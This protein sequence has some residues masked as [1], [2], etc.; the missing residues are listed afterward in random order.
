MSTRTRLAA[1][2]LAVLA[3]SALLA[4]CTV[5]P[6]HVWSEVR[7]A[8]L[9]A[10]PAIDDA[11]VVGATGP[12]GVDVRVR[13]YLADTDEVTVQ[14]VIDSAF[15]AMIAGSPVR[16]VS[17]GLDIAAAPM[18]ENPSLSARNRDI[19]AVVQQMG[20]GDRYVGGVISA[21]IDYMEERYGRWEDLRP[22][23]S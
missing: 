10:D 16:P 13:V 18:P 20:F 6:E 2:I 5:A 19:T 8:V 15:T 12:A 11:Y 9:A 3:V 21:S 23:A 14:R 17:L 4:G 1:A 7:E 22:S